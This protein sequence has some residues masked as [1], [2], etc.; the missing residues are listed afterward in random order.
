M[1][2]MLSCTQ[3]RRGESAAQGATAARVVGQHAG[4][5]ACTPKCCYVAVRSRG[6]RV[7][8]FCVWRRIGVAQYSQRHVGDAVCRARRRCCVVCC[9]LA[10]CRTAACSATARG[11]CCSLCRIGD[12]VESRCASCGA[13]RWRRRQC[14][15]ALAIRGARVSVDAA[16]GCYCVCRR[17]CRRPAPPLPAAAPGG[18]RASDR[19]VQSLLRT[20]AITA[21]AVMRALCHSRSLCAA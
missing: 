16:L 7:A 1:W 21:A 9:R 6:S 19:H 15:C 14:G 10:V 13:S 12:A 8:V 2:S 3:R 17:R 5:G 18:R 20:G 4:C 11:L